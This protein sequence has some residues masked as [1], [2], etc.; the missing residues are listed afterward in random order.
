M[1]PGV[2]CLD[3]PTYG[4]DD[5]R[6]LKLRAAIEKWRDNRNGGQL[7]IVTHDKRLLGAFDKV[8]ELT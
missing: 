7:I 3:E 4:L 2:L 1:S 6:I 8:I 5:A